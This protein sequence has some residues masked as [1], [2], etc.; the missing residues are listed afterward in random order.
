[1]VPS[2]AG[3]QDAGE[4]VDGFGGGVGLGGEILVLAIEAGIVEGVGAAVDPVGLVGVGLGDAGELVVIEPVEAAGL[5]GVHDDVAGAGVE[6]GFHGLV[7]VG[8]IDAPVELVD[9]GGQRGDGRAGGAGGVDEALELHHGDEHAVAAGAVEQRRAAERGLIERDIADGAGLVV[10][11]F[12]KDADAAGVAVGDDDGLAVIAYQAG[13]L[14]V[15]GSAAGGTVHWGF[16]QS[17]QK[18]AR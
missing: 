14:G 4:Q 18:L 11:R 15:H 13:A 5:A 6:V 1:M 16:P 2:D 9:V 8:A 3:F 7:A 12:G 10:G 17:G